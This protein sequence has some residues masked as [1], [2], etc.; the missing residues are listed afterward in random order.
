MEVFPLK[1]TGYIF[2][3]LADL[4]QTP[5]GGFIGRRQELWEIIVGVRFVGQTAESGLHGVDPTEKKGQYLIFPVFIYPKKKKTL[6]TL[7]Q[8]KD[9]FHVCR[10]WLMCG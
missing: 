5:G 1:H 7:L 2:F 10:S 8:R 9:N 3:I 6:K 4:L